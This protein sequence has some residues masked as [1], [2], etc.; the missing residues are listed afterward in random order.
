M[1][2]AALLVAFWIGFCVA[3]ALQTATGWLNVSRRD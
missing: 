3:N 2:W 1:S